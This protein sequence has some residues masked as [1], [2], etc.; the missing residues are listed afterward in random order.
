MISRGPSPLTVK[1]GCKRGDTVTIEMADPVLIGLAVTSHAAGELR[2]VTFDNVA[3]ETALDA[4]E[5]AAADAD[6]GFLATNVEDGVYDIGAFG[7]EMT[8][9]FVVRSNVDEEEASMC[10]IGR[11]YFGDTEAGLKYEQWNNTGTYGATV[12]GVA[13]YDFGVANDPGLIT[14]L[15][16]VA[17]T[18]AGL[19]DLYVNG[20]YQGFVEAPITLSG[21][22]GIGCGIQDSADADPVFDNFDG[23][24]YAVAI[25]DRALSMAEIRVNADTFFAKGPSDITTPG[26]MVQGVPNDGVTTDDNFG[27]PEAETPQSGHRRR[28]QHEVPALQG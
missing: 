5:E 18:E 1:P 14:H 17:S 26:D 23:D 15:V 11:R 25:Y 27:W 12:F 13:D 9:E 19:T 3:V 16:F 28:R 22:V 8:Y 6:P 20:A 10:L 24:V 2:T 21:E 7:G 4:W